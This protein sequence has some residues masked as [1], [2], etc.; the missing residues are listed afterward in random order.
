MQLAAFKAE[1]SGPSAPLANFTGSPTAGTAL[2]SVQFTDTSTGAPTAWAWTFG[3]GGTSTVQHPSHTYSAAGTYT[4]SLTA[5]NAAGSNT[6]TKAGYMN[7]NT[8]TTGWPNATNTGVPAGTTL[9]PYTGPCTITTPDTVIDA[10]TVDCALVIQAA[11]V[12][13]TRSKVNDQI[14]L[15]TDDSSASR[16]S[17]TVTDSEV[18][19]GVIQQAAICCGNMTLLRVN[20]HGGQTAAQCEEKSLYC[21]VTDSWLHGQA[22]PGNV[23]RHLGGFLSDGTLGSGCSGTWCIELV[24]NTVV[25]DHPVNN[26][27][28]GCS[29]D[30]N[31][32]PNF[33][34]MSK[35][36]VYNNYLGA[37]TGSAFCTY[38]G[39]KSTSPYP[40]ADHVTY[41]DN[42]FQRGTNN[43]CA[44]DGPVTDFDVNGAGNTWVNNTWDGDGTQVPPAN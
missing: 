27:D 12:S 4:G 35:V 29:G 38:G 42:V 11:D 2:L 26:V 19:A 28:E 8:P 41:Q 17:V 20:S 3:D 37:N 31:L 34:T 14:S 43:L 21:R 23:Y 24:H 15:D 7:G 5:T 25:C 39:E 1:G 44:A 9:A 30:I 6:T 32:I 36:R 18:D 22:L 16:W 10:K 13:I 40:H 33:A